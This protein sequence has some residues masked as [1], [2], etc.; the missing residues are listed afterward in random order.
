MTSEVARAELASLARHGSGAL[1]GGEH[2]IEP[3][4]ASFRRAAVLAVFTPSEGTHSDVAA[5]GVD[6]FLVQRAPWLRYHPGQVA[7]PGGGLEPQDHSAAAAAL[8]ETQEEIGLPSERVE[9]LGSLPE[10]AL[11]ISSNVVTPVLG[12]CATPGILGPGDGSEVLRTLRV[13]VARLLAPDT[14]AVV[15]LADHRSKGFALDDT[16]VWGFTGNLLDHL[17]NQLGW[18]LPWP[19]ERHY[20]MSADEA[21]G[22]APPP[23]PR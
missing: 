9:V 17:F 15:T 19:R 5:P 8:R 23:T 7:L 1:L 13:P 4:H 20:A 3:Q 11:P 21:V 10:V 22:T 12:W 2:R 16:W 18:T 6:V 14:R